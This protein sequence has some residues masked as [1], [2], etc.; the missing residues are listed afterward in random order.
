MQKQG[1]KLNKTQQKRFE[2]LKLTI[3]LV[4]RTCWWSNVRSNLTNT[5]W[6]KL[7]HKVYLKAD[8]KCEICGGIGTKHPVEC[9]EI[10]E[11]DEENKIQILKNF[12]SICPLCH[13]VKH[14]AQTYSNGKEYGDRAFKRF[15]DINELSDE[16]TKLFYDYFRQQWMKRSIEKW[17]L[18][19]TLL[20]NYDIEI[21]RTKFSEIDRDYF[22]NDVKF[23][24]TKHIPD[25]GKNHKL[26]S[27]KTYEIDQ[28]DF[29]CPY[30]E[31]RSFIR[32]GKSKNKFRYKC[33]DCNRS[34]TSIIETTYTMEMIKH[35]EL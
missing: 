34:Y 5:Q 32:Q 24:I 14:I 11:Y 21:G 16:D 33:K 7:R 17:K 18:D 1:I 29:K 4:P 28:D 30:C 15:Q 27:S 35:L 9:H 22:A 23:E 25:K 31:S 10:W 19:I 6:D 26:M 12:I 2:N 3:E 8:N 13:Q 20:E